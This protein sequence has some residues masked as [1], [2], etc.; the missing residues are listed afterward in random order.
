MHAIFIVP[1]TSGMR[2]SES[3]DLQSGQLLPFLTVIATLV[4]SS[5]PHKREIAIQCLDALLPRAEV[6][7]AVWANVGIVSG[8]F[9]SL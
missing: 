1:L 6:R 4:Q 7:Q 2:S 5:A 8:Y 9:C 3:T